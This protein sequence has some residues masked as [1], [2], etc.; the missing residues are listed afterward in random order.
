MDDWKNGIL[1]KWM[2]GML[3]YWGSGF[4]INWIVGRKEFSYLH[5]IVISVFFV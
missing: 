2:N 5:G 4:M 3:E 1:G